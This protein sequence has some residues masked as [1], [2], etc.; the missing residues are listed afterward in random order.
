MEQGNAWIKTG[1]SPRVRGNHSMPAWGTRS[2]RSI[3]ACAGEP[4]W[5]LRPTSSAMVYPR[6]CGG[7]GLP[8]VWWHRCRG[9]SPR[10]RGNPVTSISS[11]SRARSIPA[12]AGEPRSPMA[13]LPMRKVYPR[14]CGGTMVTPP[15]RN[16]NPGLSPR[17]RGNRRRPGPVGWPGWS[18][19]ACAGEPTTAIG[20]AGICQVYP[21]VCGGTRP[22]AYVLG[23]WQGLSPRVRGNPDDLQRVVR[24]DR[25]IP[26][27]AGEPPS[28]PR[29]G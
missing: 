9:L 12:C 4:A 10:V 22:L 2:V 16:A 11:G 21:R 1:L 8:A 19:P 3:P 6:V 28:P 7:T 14:V 23:N 20:T 24:G 5:C 15:P 27:C 17:V 26:A 29:T 13:P 25:S 18:I